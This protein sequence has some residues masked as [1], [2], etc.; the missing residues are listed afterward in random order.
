M[1]NYFLEERL[2]VDVR[3]GARYGDDYDVE[4]VTTVGGQEYRSLVQPFPRR[5]FT[6][7][8]NGDLDHL[9][10]GIVALY[11]RAY[12]SL[13]GFRVRCLDDYSTNGHTGAP[14]ATDQPL[15]L[16]STGVY[17]LQKQ[18]GA[19]ASPLA[20]GLPVRTLFKP[21]AGTVKAAIAGALQP[22]ISVDTTT[23]R[24]TFQNK[25]AS[26]TAVTKAAQAVATVGA[27]SF[28]VGDSVVFTGFDAGSM[29]QLNNVRAAVTATTATTIT[30]AID[31]TTFSTFTTGGSVNTRP[32]A[33]EAV[34]GG[35]EFDIPC[36][37]NSAID[38]THLARWV[39]ETG[40]IDLVE[41][42]NP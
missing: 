17:Q 12:K 4:I 34:T 14:T 40:Q 36:R 21:V 23:G 33:G 39:R 37:F 7:E 15:A 3:M 35:C 25:S 31:S 9:W 8:Y 32:Q 24:V 30:V 2:P 28:V 29:F 1:A 16:V 6:I 20:I 42:L 11:H 38:L 19:G 13:A 26:V 10:N 27:H 22:G 41:L 18:Y 5:E